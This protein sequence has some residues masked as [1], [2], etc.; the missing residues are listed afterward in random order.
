M[1]QIIYTLSL[2][3]L[4]GAC[5]DEKYADP[6]SFD[7]G[8]T[9]KLVPVK[10]NLNIQPMQSPLSSGTKAGGKTVRSTQV[11]KGLEVSMEETPVTRASENEINNFWVFQFNGTEPTSRL[12]GKQYISGNSVKDVALNTGYSNKNRIIV[13]A[14]ATESTFANPNLPIETTLADFNKMGI[15]KGN[16]FPLFSVP[17]SYDTRIIFAGSTDMVVTTDKQADIMLYRTIA[18]VNVKLSLSLEMANKGYSWNYQFMRIP[19]MSFYYS[20]GHTPAFPGE[21]VSYSNSFMNTPGVLPGTITKYLPVNLHHP[22]PYTTEE[23]R[24]VNAPANATYLQLVGANSSGRSVVYQIHL[25]S[26]FTDDYSISPNY[27]YTYNI[28]I[29][30]E[31]DDDSRVIKFIPGYFG[32][33]L[34]MYT[35]AGDPTTNPAE[36]DTWR[37]EKRIEVAVTGS[38]NMP[39]LGNTGSMPSAINDFMDGRQNTWELK[40]NAATNYP[41]L[42]QCLGM[43][44]TLQNID[45]MVWYLPSYGQSLGIYVAGSNTLKSLAS[46]FYWSSTADASNAWGTQIWTGESSPRDSK[47]GYSLRCVKDLNPN[48]VVQ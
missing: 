25:G 41:A 13:I 6:L 40:D 17:N 10:L 29:T 14:N 4:L 44:G 20:I 11:C 45:D 15:S 26:N 5:T 2:L 28:K 30:G 18:Q 22:V 46:D 8:Q 48:D 43:N 33:A 37:Y 21:T 19:D 35:A 16:D 39:W 7:G 47:S 38:N 23:R 9:G 27:S 36:A 24:V 42:N 12:I 34:K 1:K 3:I 31:S 32:G